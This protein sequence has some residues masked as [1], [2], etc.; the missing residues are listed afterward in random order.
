MNDYITHHTEEYF[1]KTYA[2]WLGKIIGIRMGSPIEGATYDQIK[3]KYGFIDRYVQKYEDYAADDDSNGPLF[4]IRALLDFPGEKQNLTPKEM[5]ETWLNYVCNGHGFFWWGGYGVSTEHTAYLNLKNGIDAPLSGSET[6]NGK[7]LA[8]QIG[9]QIFVDTWGFVLPGNPRVAA[10]LAEKMISVSHDGEGIY[11]GRFVV[12]AISSAYCA[13]SVDEIIDAGLSVIPEDCEYRKVVDAVRRYY[14]NDKEQSWEGCY[15]F[16]HANFGYD[17]YPGNCHIIPN[18]AILILSLLYG[19]GNYN[20]SLFICNSCG[21]DTDCNAGNLGSILGVFRGIEGIDASLIE[22]VKDLLLAS[23]AIGYLNI[24][25]ISETAEMF[26]K[27]GCSLASVEIPVRWRDGDGHKKYYHFLLSHS[28]NALRF[29]GPMAI[30]SVSGALK[31]VG[32]G[33]VF[34][35]TY[36][37]VSD[38]SDSRYDPSFSPLIYPGEYFCFTVGNDS[39]HEI[40][41]HCSYHEAH[42]NRE[43]KTEETILQQGETTTIRQKIVPGDGL[44]DRIGMVFPVDSKVFVQSFSIDGKVSYVLDFSKEHEDIYGFN[45]GKLHKERSQMSFSD[46]YWEYQQRDLVGSCTKDGETFTGEYGLVDYEMT[47]S[48]TP[49]RGTHHCVCIRV[50][51]LARYYAFG[52][53]GKDSIALVKKQGNSFIVL[54]ERAFVWEYGREYTIRIVARKQEITAYIDAHEMLHIEDSSFAFGCYGFSILDNSRCRF[55]NIHI[56]EY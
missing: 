16:I 48:I 19:G 42:S 3:G 45:N 24:N 38:L 15:R 40:P 4:F 22:P 53:W 12:A 44:V 54:K 5:G 31:L 41:M 51:G 26:S 18:T 47:T 8:E 14:Q 52:L 6:M 39:G 2:G 35:K 10:D 33:R 46:G 56:N 29:E 21:W 32:N 20:Q 1:Q 30:S 28:R 43:I 49:L 17:K 9:G 13:R 25:T 55:G 7:T 34:Y 36:Y 37:S 27:M 50:Q 23:S 11:G